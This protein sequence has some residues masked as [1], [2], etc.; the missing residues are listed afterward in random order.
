KA[1]ARMDAEAEAI[2]LQAQKKQADALAAAA[3]LNA[4]V[5][6]AALQKQM[7]ETARIEK[8]KE[9]AALKVLEEKKKMA[10]EAA[11][12]AQRDPKIQLA[13]LTSPGI[14]DAKP[15]ASDG[16]VAIAANADFTNSIGMVLVS[17]PSGFW[18]GK[19]EVTQAEY[20]KVMGA[21]PS[22][23]INERQP[24]ERVGWQ[25]AKDF[26]RKLTDLERNNLPQGKVYSLPTEK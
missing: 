6:A 16:R 2:R 7:A 9:A 22:K 19:F 23:S 24:V 1:R 5:E 21:N 8:E 15:A 18:A 11:R 4:D 20:Q 10:E 3:K 26:C 25:E 17:I 14:P 13:S 12:S